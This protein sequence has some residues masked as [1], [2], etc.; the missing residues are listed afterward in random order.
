MCQLNDA[1]VFRAPAPLPVCLPSVDAGATV[2]AT[3]TKKVRVSIGCGCTELT[4]SCLS[5]RFHPQFRDRNRRDIGKSQSIWTNSKMETPS[6]PPWARRSLCS[7]AGAD[8]LAA[9]VGS[10]ARH[11]RPG[12]DPAVLSARR[13]RNA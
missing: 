2:P 5:G 6:S 7:Q 10:A 9:H 13:A 4:R 3:C 12:A 11:R 8:L 1:T